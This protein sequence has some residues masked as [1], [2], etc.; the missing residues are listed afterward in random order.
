MKKFFVHDAR[1]RFKIE[2]GS[3]DLG[4]IDPPFGI[5]FNG[6]AS[7]YNR[8]KKNVVKDY[9]E[10]DVKDIPQIAK[11]Y[12]RIL[13]PYGTVWVI[14]GWTNLRYWEMAFSQYFHQIGHVIWKYQF[15][16]YTKRKP[17]TSHYHLL[18]Y[19]KDDKVWRWNRVKKYDEDVW[20]IRRPYQ[21]GG[22][23]YPNKLPP[24]LVERIIKRSSNR[25]DW[26]YDCFVGS[27]TTVK[28]AESLGRIGIGSDIRDNRRFWK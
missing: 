16:V 10:F 13:K 22:L 28:V 2:T 24:R 19:T 8:K 20:I 6:R 7:N 5:K 4:I 23:K 11:E 12:F 27:G 9:Q 18:I 21:K 17:V 25:G 14:M 15:G 3:I 26:V 1:Q